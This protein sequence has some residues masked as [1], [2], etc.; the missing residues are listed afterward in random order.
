MAALSFLADVF[1]P[2]FRMTANES[3]EQLA[4]LTIVEIDHFD[5]VFAQ[6][7]EPAC[8]SAALAHHKRANAKLPYQA[9]AVPAWRQSGHHHQ[10]AVA[11]LATGAAKGVGFA[12]DA[13]V[14]LLDPPIAPS[15]QQ[16]AFARK[17]RRADW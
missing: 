5:A 16:V 12:V 11:A 1:V 4:A 2:D 9:A 6:P 17:K 8:E 13:R 10:I 7:V 15:A 3:F 14:T